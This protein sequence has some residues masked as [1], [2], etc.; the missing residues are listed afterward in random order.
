MS[1]VIGV[2]RRVGVCARTP[3]PIVD[4]E[5]ASWTASHVHGEGRILATGAARTGRDRD[6]WESR[7]RSNAAAGCI[8]PI[9]L[10]GGERLVASLLIKGQRCGLA[11]KRGE[12]AE[13][14]AGVEHTIGVV[15]HEDRNVIGSS[16]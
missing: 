2:I 11:E 1:G 16:S 6:R 12:R 9:E 14:F 15:I 7:R 3:T 13:A 10:Q 5:D 4:C 8:C